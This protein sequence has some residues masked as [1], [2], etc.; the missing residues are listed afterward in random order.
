M[1]KIQFELIVDRKRRIE[2]I[3]TED[4]EFFPSVFHPLANFSS[5]YLAFFLFSANHSVN[6]SVNACNVE[7]KRGNPIVTR[8][9]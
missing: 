8:E 1:F 6:H 7:V 4:P 9:W 5:G 3:E 2:I